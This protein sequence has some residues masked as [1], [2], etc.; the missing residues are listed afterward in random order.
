MKTGIIVRTQNMRVLMSKMEAL[1][2]VIMKMEGWL[3]LKPDYSMERS[4][5]M[6]NEAWTIFHCLCVK[7]AIY[8]RFAK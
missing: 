2:G 6:Q 5:T 3:N 7:L 4:T 1:C 8:I